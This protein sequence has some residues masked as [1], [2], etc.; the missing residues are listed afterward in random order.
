MKK[1]RKVTQVKAMASSLKRDNQNVRVFP[2]D[3]DPGGM[4]F[5]YHERR[6]LARTGSDA[7]AVCDLL[8]ISRTSAHHHPTKLSGL[9]VIDL[10]DQPQFADISA[11]MAT[12]NAALPGKASPD[13]VVHIAPTSG[14]CPAVEAVPVSDQCP[15]APYPDRR[16]ATTATGEGVVVVVVDTGFLQGVANQ[17]DW[18]DDHNDV[19]GQAEPATVDWYRGHGTFVAGVVRAVA[20]KA[21]VHVLALMYSHGAMVESEIVRDLTDALALSPDIISISAGMTTLDGQDPMGFQVFNEELE[22]NHP[23]TLVVAAAGNDG[24]R[25]HFFPA[26]FP[27]AIGVGALSP[28]GTIAPYSNFGDSA[29]IYALGTDLINAYPNGNFKYEEE[30]R[31]GKPDGH[32][33]KRLALW[34]GT[35]FSA[36][37]VTGVIAARASLPG[38]TV[39]GAWQ[40]LQA[41]A[42]QRDP[43]LPILSISSI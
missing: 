40:S 41:E 10:P 6:L 24:N 1:A 29:D 34:S 30:P 38:G 19:S 14:S 31:R 42:G 7:D 2:S 36:P 26:S 11:V 9:S 16:D 37:Y 15:I 28:D 22:N 25:E 12:V 23:N 18:L 8:G 43:V 33:T 17:L 4:D 35:S 39:P 3:A 13:H 5:M 20:P 32:F 21:E 27:W